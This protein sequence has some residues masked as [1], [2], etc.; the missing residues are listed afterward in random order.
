M[1]LT[2]LFVNKF[3]TGSVAVTFKPC[4]H[5]FSLGLFIHGQ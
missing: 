3:K 4:Y 5:C 1:S 2:D